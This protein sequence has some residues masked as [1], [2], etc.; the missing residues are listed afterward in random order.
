M[1]NRVVIIIVCFALTT[2]FCLVP[3]SAFSIR[4]LFEPQVRARKK[5]QKPTTGTSRVNRTPAKDFS[6]FSHRSEKHKSLACDKCHS[7]PTTN[8]LVASGFP[9]VA[10]FPTHKSCAGCHRNEFFRGARPVICSICHIRVAPR[11][12]E[13]FAFEKPNQPSQFSTIFPHDKHQDVIAANR[14]AGKGESAHFSLYRNATEEKVRP[15]YNNCTLCHQTESGSP[16][17]VTVFQDGFQPPAGTFKTAPIGHGSCFEC[18]WKNQS[19]TQRDCAGCHALAQLDIPIALAP[20]RLSLKFTH[21]REQHEAECTAC[22][23]NI[24]GVTSLIGIK[25]D[26]PITSCS[27]SSCHGARPDRTVV[28]IETEVEKH[29]DPSFVCFKCH[30]SDVGKK[31][32]PASHI[33]ALVE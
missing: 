26:V 8:W 16:R 24:T 33:A 32:T 3:Q 5:K 27:A 10:D 12:R 1:R 19:P 14:S 6:V 20:K 13:R 17:P 28:T 11:G 2:V 4:G 9:D 18:H 7:A 31:S 23:I 29:R 22:H 21:L 15:D 25:P 30:T